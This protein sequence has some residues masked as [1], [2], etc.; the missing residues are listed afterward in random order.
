[1]RAARYREDS[2]IAPIARVRAAML[3]MTL[4][5]FSCNCA[6]V[7]V[8]KPAIA[9]TEPTTFKDGKLEKGAI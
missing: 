1:M 7:A 4:A 3:E 9:F 5:D 8:Y 2:Q 6:L